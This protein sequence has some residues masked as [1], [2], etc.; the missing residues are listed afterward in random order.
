MQSSI[1]RKNVVFVFF[2]FFCLLVA[3]NYRNRNYW[4]IPPASD[5]FDE[6]AAGWIGLSLIK[7]GIPTSWSYIPDYASGVPHGATLT[8]SGMSILVDGQAP[9]ITTYSEFPKPLRLTTQ[10][11][12]EGFRSHFNMVSPDLEQP[13][14][15]GIIIA[16]PLVLRGVNTFSE[17]TL[18]VL[19]Q[20]FIYY[21]VA[22]TLLVI[23]IAK[24]LYGEKVALISGII[25]ATTPTIV[26]GSRLALPENIL[27]LLFLIEVYVLIKYHKNK[28]K[29]LITIAFLISFI[30]PLVKPFGLSGAL[31]GAGYAFFISKETKT[32][33]RFLLTGTLS[34]LCYLVYGIV[35]DKTTFIAIFNYQAGRFFSGPQVFILKIIIPKITKIFYDGWIFFGWISV[36]HL[37]FLKENKRDL[38]ILVP[39]VSYMIVTGVFGGEDY[40]W[41]RFPLYPYLTIASGLLVSKIIGNKSFFAA[42]IFLITVVAFCLQWGLGDINWNMHINAFRIMVAVALFVMTFYVWQ[43][44]RQHYIPKIFMVI[45]F[46]FSLYLNTRIINN[47]SNIWPKLGD[48]SALI[49]DRK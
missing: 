47:M 18:K 7:T 28:N 25:Y 31:I 40:G 37:S 34:F 3:F 5:T 24:M 35:I 6:F 41:Y 49:L 43:K 23:L 38:Y 17:V 4:S 14:L 12:L 19:R 2:I 10:F 42:F 8:I 45:V 39:V 22:S 33:F 9:T 16:M 27:S 48:D 26:I 32:A 15:G 1:N 20:P 13:P 21:G 44:G 36:V 29:K 11:E 30:A 46:L